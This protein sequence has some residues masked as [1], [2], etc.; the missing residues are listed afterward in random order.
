MR[1]KLSDL[2]A[3]MHFATQIHI[4]FLSI[5][6][7]PFLI[8]CIAVSFYFKSTLQTKIVN[9]MES[10]LR[11]AA[12]NISENLQLYETSAFQTIFSQ[13]FTDQVTRLN[14][15]DF[16]SYVYARQDILDYFRTLASYYS[17]IHSMALKT[18]GRILWYGRLENDNNLYSAYNYYLL[19]ENPEQS[20]ISG[21]EKWIHTTYFSELTQK[22]YQMATYRQ[23]CIDYST[24]SKMGKFLLNIDLS[25]FRS[26]LEEAS[27]A[28]D[29]KDNYLF[30]MDR[31]GEIIY[32]TDE[33]L[34]GAAFDSV[35]QAEASFQAD[36]SFQTDTSFQ[37]GTSFQADT[38]FPVTRGNSRLILSGCQIPNT[39]WYL[40]DVL[41]R[42]Y[43]NREVNIAVPLLLILALLLLLTASF[44]V[45]WIS[46]SISKSIR[47]IVKTMQ[48]VEDGK[49]T[50]KVS[51]ESKNEISVIGNQFNNMMDTIQNQ[52]ATIQIITER[53][54]E[55]E[56][57]SLESQIDPHFLYNTLD[58][59][60]WIAI[61][62]D[63]PE[64]S[65]MLCNLSLLMRYRI[66]KSNALVTMEEDLLYLEKYLILQKMRYS[67]NFNYIINIEP[68][69]KKCMVHKLLF[70]PF[71]E[72]SLI[73][74][75]GERDHG[76]I[77]KVLI[78]DRDEGHFQ[79][80][81]GD[82]GKG[83]DQRQL[84]GLMNRTEDA[85]SGHIG[86]GNVLKRLEL[87]YGSE[88]SINIS[89]SPGSGTEI[90][91]VIPKIYMRETEESS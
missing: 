58:S 23:N 70:Q 28:D 39:D 82:N 29:L 4:A 8:V 50:V 44:A 10:N 68:G 71:I 61:D 60:N 53:K 87:Y 35:F 30:I 25:S 52:I 20:I 77:L 80:F 32:S 47:E 65:S 67:D 79:L 43:A 66:K 62:N 3:D 9:Y 41:D 91:V 48:K 90:T 7:I 56:I 2:W 21:P 31:K 46:K 33:A 69:L 45:S 17:P 34:V 19:D 74:G 14:E 24:N 51:S 1:K 11:Q 16:S 72:N 73:H 26:I 86:I 13:D 12:R 6:I 88:Y 83:M 85:S 42:S 22:R 89:S 76:G 40:V 54:K 57:S 5:F 37:A 15:G 36:T 49:L 78:S 84:D 81:I 18:G 64:I 63:E 38:S 75:F 27:V 59:I 55:A